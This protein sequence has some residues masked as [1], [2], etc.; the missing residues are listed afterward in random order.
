MKSHR[1]EGRNGGHPTDRPG[2]QT[3]M[4]ALRAVK[5]GVPEARTAA[6]P[7]TSVPAGVA[8]RHPVPPDDT[9]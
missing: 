1:E 7:S 8:L 2:L 4:A 9:D 3:S 5:R 6:P